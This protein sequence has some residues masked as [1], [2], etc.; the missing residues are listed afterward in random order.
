MLKQ[1]IS[2]NRHA[3]HKHIL[4]AVARPELNLLSVLRTNSVP[5]QRTL[6]V[7]TRMSDFAPLFSKCAGFSVEEMV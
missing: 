4:R 3:E 7:L 5:D 2:L 6:Y 1:S